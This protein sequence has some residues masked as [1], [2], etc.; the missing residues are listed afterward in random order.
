MAE[1]LRL[2]VV[3]PYGPVFSDEVDEVV[4]PGDE[5]E[6]GVL[7]GHVPFITTLKIGILTYKKNGSTGYMFVNTGYAEVK[8]DRVLILADSA[9]KAEDIDVERARE[10]LRRAEERLKTQDD[11]DFARAQAA[12]QRATTRIEVAKKAGKA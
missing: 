4:A 10:A 2:E 3:T 1:K 12:L 8:D 6:F 9:E 7:P 11:I 5:G